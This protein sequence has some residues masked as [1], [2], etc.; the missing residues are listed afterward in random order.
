M[1]LQGGPGFFPGYLPLRREELTPVSHDPSIN[2]YGR[3]LG[4]T[5]ESR[6]CHHAAS[7]RRQTRQ[8][9]TKQ[10][11]EHFA[12]ANQQLDGTLPEPAA[13]GTEYHRQAAQQ[14]EHQDYSS[15]CMAIAAAGEAS[16]SW[17]IAADSLVWSPMAD[18][19]LNR[20]AD[21]IVTG[22]RF[23]AL[24]DPDNLIS[25]YDTIFNS[26][27]EDYGEGVPYHIEYQLKADP[28]FNRPA[29]WVEDRG[30]WFAD[31]DGRPCE[32]VGILRPI[33][34]RHS[35]D[36]MLSALSH[37]DPLTG[38]MNRTRLDEALDEAIGEA[39]RGEQPCAF[40]VA[41]IRNL[42]VVNEAYGF[43]VAD[44]VI[45]AMATRLRAVMRTG[46]G[47]ARYSGSKFGFILNACTAEELPVAI[48]RFLNAA[49]DSV[50]ET[51][52]G[53]VWALLSIGAVLLPAHA[54]NSLAA[55]A[56]AEETLSLA[57]RLSSD[58]YVV[59]QPSE[60][61]VNDRIV[62]T[63]CAAEIVECLKTN[64][65]QLAYQPMVDAI[66]GEVACHEALL[67]MRDGAG[68]LVTAAH[69]VPVAERLG[70]IRLVDRS[71]VQLAL[72]TLHTYSDARLSI[73]LSA[74]TAND[75]RW[76]L[77]I[78][79][80]IE[81]AG[82]VA[83]RLT[84]EITE[85]TALNDLTVALEFLDKL[86][87]TGC[88]VAIDDF[89]AGFTSFR[90]LRDLPVD[91]IKLDGSYCRN[92]TKDAENVYFARTLIEMAHHFGIRTVAEW[93]E[94]EGDAEIL[95]SLGIDFLQGNHIGCPGIEPPWQ[96]AA[97]PSFDFGGP[98]PLAADEEF[99]ADTPAEALNVPVA[100][101]TPILDLPLADVPTGDGGD[102]DGGDMGEITGISSP[103]NTDAAPVAAP[104]M[105]PA[106]ASA[107]PE[108]QPQ[109]R[110]ETVDA[111]ISAALGT[112]AGTDDQAVD[113]S[114]IET[115]METGLSKLREALDL[116]NQHFGP[117]RNGND[118]TGQARLA[119]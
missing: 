49:R 110:P 64:K 18:M 27:V 38:M 9:Q 34:E 111:D 26:T 109:I 79:E 44:E 70:L 69:L 118:D 10:M 55:K 84:V 21:C 81:M 112:Q 91:I 19:V 23:A 89:G 108:V 90:N 86:R 6:G 106:E 98:T 62:N 101:D 67:R 50:I 104:D 61:S 43:E 72:E 93:V 57:L 102:M 78:I 73:N 11:T 66:T 1:A 53:P 48:E 47:I 56:L 51:S 31:G 85:T 40:A 99:A 14:S 65:F 60:K 41:T 4:W 3:S 68:E 24:L 25:R 36:Q 75:S 114:A 80:M 97:A 94:T 107:A 119:S 32:A 76:N 77:Q 29:M 15:I 71:V 52:H 88:C 63:R 28:A 87:D 92:L 105:M 116:L 100:D 30:R 2:L 54:E 74:T 39:K 8:R 113:E 22:K 12:V 5:P 96:N 95:R 13:D 42:D 45:A 20:P 7:S 16:Y 46:D 58:S 35:R 59:H 83:S 103:D 82:E 115:E 117:A 33:D 17:N 37:T